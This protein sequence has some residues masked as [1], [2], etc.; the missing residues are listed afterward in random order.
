M[1]H[2]FNDFRNK[3]PYQPPTWYEWQP[4]NPFRYLIVIAT[5]LVGIPFLF[6]YIL[7][8]FGALMQLVFWDWYMYIREQSKYIDKDHYK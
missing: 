8:P 2:E 1:Q 4:E 3:Q 7:S 5:F 6:G